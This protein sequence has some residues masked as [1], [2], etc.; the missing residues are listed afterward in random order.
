MATVDDTKAIADLLKNNGH[1]ADDPQ[2]EVIIKYFNPDS[3]RPLAAVL[4]PSDAL[5]IELVNL[6]RS[7][8]VEDPSVLWT[9]QKGLTAVGQQW[10]DNYDE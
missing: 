4:Y 1:F 7:P 2:P 8:F 5:A 9:K 3:T 10:I 6:V